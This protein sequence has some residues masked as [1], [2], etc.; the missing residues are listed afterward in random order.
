MKR[1]LRFSILMLLMAV[2]GAANAQAENV[3]FTFNTDEGLKALNI[4]KP[5]RGGKT[6]LNAEY[7]AG[8]VSMKA[9]K[10]LIW[11]K[12]GKKDRLDLRVYKNGS[13]TFSVPADYTITEVKME[14]T[15]TINLSNLTNGSWRGD[16]KKISFSAT[17][18]QYINTI[19]VTYKKNAVAPTSVS[20]TIGETGYA[21]LYYSSL[22]LTV[23]AGVKGY[24]CSLA[25]GS[26]KMNEAF[27]EGQTIPAGTGVLL[28]AETGTYTFKVSSETGN[29]VA[30][31]WL[32]GSD[33]EAMTEGG[34]RYY[35]L[36]L[37]AKNTAGS[38]GF[39]W[40]AANGGAFTNGAHKAYLCVEPGVAGAKTCYRFDGQTT[41]IDGTRADK[42]T[43][44][45]G[46]VYNLA[47]QRVDRSYKG[48]V[49]KNGKK[50]IQ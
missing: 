12:K 22:A 28:K 11:N 19:M 49:I 16:Q 20:V 35:M 2:C 32:K 9:E 26:F 15:K 47:G 46:A 18:A 34:E 21:T 48:V 31:N 30:D 3:T 5:E 6:E 41:A 23:P 27:A 40:G 8:E 50:Y 10:S 39:Y 4:A 1:K 44:A 37:D 42:P 29:A 33:E 45:D 24:A 43:A 38:V 7:K 13:L 25:D 14:G 17:G 36:S